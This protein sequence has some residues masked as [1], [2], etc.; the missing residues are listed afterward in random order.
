MRRQ[1]SCLRARAKVKRRSE[2]SSEL[3]IERVRRICL[4]LPGTWEKISHGEPTWFVDKKVFAMF[5][6]NHHSDGHIAV[7]LP[8][9]IGVQEAL[10]KKSPKKFYRPPYVGVR[11]WIGVDVDR[12]S[13]KELRGHIEEAWRLIAPK[14]LQHGE[15]ASNSE[16]L[17]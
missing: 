15:L 5:S 1:R 10:I 14:K 3:Q 11:G 4:A 8:A 2:N 7:T 6:N 17:H 13:D 9:A 16:R 12:V